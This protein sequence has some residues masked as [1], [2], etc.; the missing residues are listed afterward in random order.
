MERREFLKGLA[1]GGLTLALNP[2]KA[3]ASKAKDSASVI[4]DNTPN[5]TILHCNDVHSHIDAFP[6]NDPN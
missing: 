1:I 4:A 2:L 3:L 6:D 5:L